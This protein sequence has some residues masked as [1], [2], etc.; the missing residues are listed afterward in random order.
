MPQLSQ[1]VFVGELF[2]PW[3]HFCGP[4]LDVLQQVHISPLLRTPHLHTNAFLGRNQFLALAALWSKH[5]MECVQFKV[6]EERGEDTHSIFR[7]LKI[8]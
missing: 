6:G 8:S 3:D 2:H 7:L 5:K 1:P 4:P